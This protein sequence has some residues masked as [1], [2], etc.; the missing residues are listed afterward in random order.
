MKHYVFD[1][2]EV[3]NEKEE[4]A[5]QL[6]EEFCKEE[7]WREGDVIEWIDNKDGSYSLVNKTKNSR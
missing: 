4:L 6:S 5:I 2:V 1:V 3:E 7:D